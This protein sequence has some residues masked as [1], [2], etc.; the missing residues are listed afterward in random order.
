M[1]D[2]RSDPEKRVQI[3]CSPKAILSYTLSA[4]S[5]YPIRYKVAENR[6][7]YRMGRVQ[8]IYSGRERERASGPSYIKR[9][10]PLTYSPTACVTTSSQPLSP[11]T[12]PHFTCSLIVF[13]TPT[14]I[15]PSNR[16]GVCPRKANGSAIKGDVT[17]SCC[18]HAVCCWSYNEH[19]PARL[20]ERVDSG[21]GNRTCG[22]DL[23]LLHDFSQ[24]PVCRTSGRDPVWADTRHL[25]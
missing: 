20:Q 8:S 10:R 7:C 24:R 11:P 1:H 13:R 4:L 5:R 25:R 19:G 6:K 2:R 23:W 18:C 16:V 12:P 21:S 22:T 14:T 3:I 17:K 15:K 9:Y